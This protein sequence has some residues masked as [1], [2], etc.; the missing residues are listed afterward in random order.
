MHNFSWKITNTYGRSTALNNS[1]DTFLTSTKNEVADE[2]APSVYLAGN[3]S[4]LST[5]GSHMYQDTLLTNAGGK[6]LHLNLQIL[7]GQMFLTNRF[8]HGILNILL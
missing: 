8:L 3:S 1:I 5:A 6:M 7:I 2:K 4:V